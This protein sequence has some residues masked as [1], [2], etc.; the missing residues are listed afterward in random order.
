M[1]LGRNNKYLFFFLNLKVWPFLP[2]KPFSNIYAK[3][4]NH[5]IWV[6]QLLILNKS[7]IFRNIHDSM[8]TKKMRIL[9]TNIMF[10][11]INMSDWAKIFILHYQLDYCCHVTILFFHI[12]LISDKIYG[13]IAAWKILSEM[14]TISTFGQLQKWVIYI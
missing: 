14:T 6:Y 7:Y 3:I 8:G 5:I 2:I 13:D 12:F 4:L 9:Q 11:D 1:I 10:F